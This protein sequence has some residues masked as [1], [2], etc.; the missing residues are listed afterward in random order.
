MAAVLIARRTGK[1]GDFARFLQLVVFLENE[2]RHAVLVIFLRPKD[3]EVPEAYDLALRQGHDAADEAVE[4]QLG[5][6]VGIE[7]L[8]ALRFL[9]LP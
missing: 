1:Q 2:G 6:G 5:I 8:L 7:S 4:L 9:P 3:V